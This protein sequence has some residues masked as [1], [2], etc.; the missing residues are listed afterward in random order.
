MFNNV[1]LQTLLSLKLFHINKNCFY[2]ISFKN[3]LATCDN[4]YYISCIFIL[5]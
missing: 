3:T 4:I 2:I 5:L 1:V